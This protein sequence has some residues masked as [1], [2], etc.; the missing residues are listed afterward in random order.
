MFAAGI[1]DYA[2][3]LVTR[4]KTGDYQSVAAS[5]INC[6]DPGLHQKHFGGLAQDALGSSTTDF[7]HMVPML[8]SK[9][10]NLQ[11]PLVWAQDSNALVCST[12]QHDK[13]R[14]F[15]SDQVLY[16]SDLFAMQFSP[17]TKTAT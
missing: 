6:T 4:I 5:W 10:T 9:R 3:S 16:P 7:D 11:C 8:L 15:L 17:D 13:N 12:G 2:D 14:I 1:T